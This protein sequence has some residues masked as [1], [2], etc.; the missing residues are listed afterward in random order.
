MRVH[1]RFL[2]I[3]VATLLLLPEWASA[4]NVQNVFGLMQ[5]IKSWSLSIVPLAIG[6]IMIVILWHIGQFVLH[7]G[8]ERERD[9]HKKFIIWAVVAVFAILAFWGISYAILNSFF[10]SGDPRLGTPGFI[11]KNGATPF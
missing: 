11:D 8:D 6:I 10:N 5:R 1:H 4:Q 2:S 7:A 9:E 3:L